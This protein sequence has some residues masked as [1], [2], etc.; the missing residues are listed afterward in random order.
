MKQTTGTLGAD[1]KPCTGCG[2]TKVLT[3]FTFDKRRAD[4]RQSRCKACYNAYKKRYREADREHYLE[5]RRLEYQRN[6]DSAARLAWL[7]AN[8]DLINQ[9]ARDRIASLT[10]EERERFLEKRRIASSAYLARNP[11]ACA[12]RIRAW[13]QANPDKR[14]DQ[15]HRRRARKLGNGRYEEFSRDEI[16]ERDGWICGICDR[17]VDEALRWP[18][19]RSASLDHV[20]PL[21]FGGEHTRANSRIAHWICNVRRGADRKRREI[22]T[23]PTT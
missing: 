18:D 20:V 10:D 5:L 3:E 15:V 23:E 13:G 21:V 14:V 12:E 19:L 7:E 1:S 9:Q 4:G 22:A 17:P 2:V 6:K 16:G 11:E 8:R